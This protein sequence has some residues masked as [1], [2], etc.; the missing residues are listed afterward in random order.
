MRKK[1]RESERGRERKGRQ[2]EGRY[3]GREAEREKRWR[4]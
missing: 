3:R 2:T 4:Q 1:G